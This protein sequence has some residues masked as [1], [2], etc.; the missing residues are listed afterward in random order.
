MIPAAPAQFQ[1][2]IGYGKKKYTCFCFDKAVYEL[3]HTI[4]ITYIWSC[5]CYYHFIFPYKIVKRKIVY[6]YKFDRTFLM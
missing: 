4:I 1:S 2:V 5:N 3:I 6:R